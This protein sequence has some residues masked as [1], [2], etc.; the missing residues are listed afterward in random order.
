LIDNVCLKVKCYAAQSRTARDHKHIINEKESQGGIVVFLWVPV[1][2]AAV[3][4][5]VVVVAAVT[6]SGLGYVKM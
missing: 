1:A 6:D 3:A 2:A 4:V 5:V